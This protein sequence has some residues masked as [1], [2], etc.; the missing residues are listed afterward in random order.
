MGLVDS[1]YYG[2]YREV[3]YKQWWGWAIQTLDIECKKVKIY[4][5][6]V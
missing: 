6:G 4:E 2:L 3:F 5:E 1:T